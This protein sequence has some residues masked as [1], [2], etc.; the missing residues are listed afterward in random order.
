MYKRYPF[1]ACLFL[2]SVSIQ[3]QYSTDAFQFL[4]LPFSSHAAALGGVNISVIADDLTM[5]L[6]NPALLSCVSNR[7]LTLNYMRYMEG[8]NV[9]GAAFA[10]TAGERGT[11]AAAAQ[12]VDY[13]KMTETTP[14][15]I[16]TGTFTAKDMALSGIY[17][18][19]LSNRWSGGVRA[20]FIYSDYAGYSS[21]AVGVDLGVN[22]Y[23]AEHDFSFSAVARNLGGQ[24][25][26]FDE[27]REN[28]PAELLVGI[29][30]G[31]AHAPFRFSLTLHDLTR[32]GGYGSKLLNHVTLGVDFLPAKAF[33][34]AVGYQF[35]RSD[36]MKVNG[37][38]HG[39]GFTGGIGIQLKRVKLGLS[40]AKYHVSSSSLMM[41][42]SYTL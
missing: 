25:K 42:L 27:V 17:T 33:Y 12:Y 22:Y 37:S 29:S 38:G 2:C 16:E 39:A 14:E 30:Q 32:W 7:T 4:R 6:H 41:N 31:L 28:L 40:Y 34:V 20:A 36:E 15:N 13:G 10:H 23:H 35:R 9:A 8:V 5:A 1:I 21:M 26:T 19:D 3:A 11:W 18:Y 24:L